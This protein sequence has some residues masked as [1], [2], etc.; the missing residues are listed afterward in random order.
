[1]HPVVIQILQTP[2]LQPLQYACLSSSSPSRGYACPY[3]QEERSQRRTTA[4]LYHSAKLRVT[5]TTPDAVMPRYVHVR[6][7][8]LLHTTGFVILHGVIL[9][10]PLILAGSMGKGRG[11]ESLL[12]PSFDEGDVT[13]HRLHRA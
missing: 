6:L 3:G 10:Q 2:Y 5:Y 11:Y 7:P 4:R 9:D 1:M 12:F 13:V 8:V